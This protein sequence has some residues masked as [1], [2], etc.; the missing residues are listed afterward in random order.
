M[1]LSPLEVNFCMLAWVMEP[2]H[3]VKEGVNLPCMLSGIVHDSC[4]EW[5]EFVLGLGTLDR[6]TLTFFVVLLWNIW[7]RRNTLVHEDELIPASDWGRCSRHSQ[8]WTVM[9]QK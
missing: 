8:R 4:K 9:N 1:M 5:L 2:A 3:C 6:E 7:K